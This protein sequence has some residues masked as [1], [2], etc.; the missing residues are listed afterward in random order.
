[1]ARREAS[2]SIR[3]LDSLLALVE[4]NGGGVGASAMEQGHPMLNVQETRQLVRSR[5]QTAFAGAP[6]SDDLIYV[7]SQLASGGGA[8]ANELLQDLIAPDEFVTEVGGLVERVASQ[9]R[10][11]EEALAG[12]EEGTREKGQLAAVVNHRSL[13]LSR[14]QEILAIA[15]SMTQGM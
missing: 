14:V 12:L 15:R 4:D 5:L 13:A 8:V 6:L 10:E 7:A 11:L 3:L 9:Q 2:P 1:M